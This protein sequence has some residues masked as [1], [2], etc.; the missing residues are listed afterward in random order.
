MAVSAQ[1]SAPVKHPLCHNDK[2]YYYQ[3]LSTRKSL[4]MRRLNR[5]IRRILSLLYL[6]SSML[7][8]AKR[9]VLI[10]QRFEEG[11]SLTDIAVDFDISPQRVWQI[12]HGKNMR[13]GGRT[14]R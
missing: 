4:Q 11:E 7:T 12:V 1:P 8:I 9:N 14:A 2:R 3:R 5:S 10:K 6:F 13:Q